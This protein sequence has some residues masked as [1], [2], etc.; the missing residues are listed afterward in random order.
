M[1]LVSPILKSCPTHGLYEPGNPSIPRGKCPAC[2]RADNQRRKVKQ[3]DQGR[4]TAHWKNLA[5]RAKQ[6][7]GYRCQGCGCPEVR[8]SRGWLSV[9][10]RPELGGNHRAATLDDVVV[11]CLSCHGT[12]DAPRAQGSQREQPDDDSP[13]LLI[14]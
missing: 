1:V 5:R 3:R 2:Y 7:A 9:H 12:L 8:D 11:L 14:A 10:L 13:P 4:T 6:A